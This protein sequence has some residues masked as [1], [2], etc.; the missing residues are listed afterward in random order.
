MFL[1]ESE[2]NGGPT[3][4]FEGHQYGHLK[5]ITRAMTRT[6]DTRASRPADRCVQIEISLD[7]EAPDLSEI[8]V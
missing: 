4:A 3:A 5:V 1:K 8:C 7:S 2:Q 6:V